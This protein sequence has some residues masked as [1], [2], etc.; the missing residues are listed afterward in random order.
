M[1]S[2]PR[3]IERWLPI[4][5]LGEESVRE[6]RS[7]TALPPVYYLHVWW[8]RRPLVASRAAILASLLPADADHKQFMQ[9][10]G[11]HGDPIASRRKIDQ[12][13]RSGVR[14]EG[15]AYSYDRAFKYTPTEAEQSWIRAQVGV[16][17]RSIVALD[18][19]AG[20]GSV[21]MEAL[22]VGLST[23]GNDLNPVAT[24]IQRATYEWPAKYGMA[25]V[26]EFNRL[27]AEFV[28]R[29]EVRLK[30]FFP[31]EPE[32]DC[33]STNYI[34]ARTVRCPYCEGVVPL[35]P[36][37]RLAPDGT[38]VR[39]KPNCSKVVAE[40][41]CEFEI[42]KK[43]ADQSEGTVSGGDASCPFSDCGRV[44]EGDEI[45]RQAQ[46][47]QMGE[48]LY[49]VVFKRR[50][51]TGHTKT[52]KE[53]VKWIRG[54]RGPVV[55][56][57]NV[58]QIAAILAD[59]IPE[60]EALG[61]VPT[62][63]FP[64]ET[65]DD[66]PIQYGMPLWRDQFSKRQLL[67]HATSVE[68]FRELYNEAPAGLND[69]GRAAFIYL[70]L[71]LDKML[72]YNSRKSVWMSTRE[73]VA[74]SFNRHDFSVSWSHAEMIV[75]LDEDG[76]DWAIGQTTK[77]IKELVELIQ[78]A[79]A[80]VAAPIAKPQAELGLALETELPLTPAAPWSP[81]PIKVTNKS[82]DALDHLADGSVDVVVMDPPYYDNVMYAELSDFF[83][84]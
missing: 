74:N 12:A 48:Q 81:P 29:R 35:S 61:V 1:S 30:D 84:V 72:N 20:G 18:P 32:K 31:A 57:D 41:V 50:T 42:V 16:D 34:W 51:V 8:A 11:I 43:L 33:I 46:A 79:S 38:G 21:P 67:G 77:C 23:F 24:L 2:S 63:K 13:K 55:S 9:A 45:K 83:Y 27:A 4:A 73:V 49:T 28:K 75:L 69:V 58:S 68:I 66:R 5:E 60:W 10:L 80:R 37:W 7:M 22:R 17:L 76:Y 39:I 40:R 6:R 64:E 78:P 19:T 71:S 15:D 54:Y 56:D 3:L 70:A 44:I 14:F 52:G 36:N 82:G 53:K 47:G 25:L 62:E 59:K 65:N 26:H